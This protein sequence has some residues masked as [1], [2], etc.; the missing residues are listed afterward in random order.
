[1]GNRGMNV[2]VLEAKTGRVLLNKSYD[3]HG[4]GNAA[5]RM[6]NDI[7]RQ[8]NKSIVIVATRDEAT[9]LLK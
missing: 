2:V 8:P 7:N 6:I 5:G 9:R 4:D 1:M 3:T